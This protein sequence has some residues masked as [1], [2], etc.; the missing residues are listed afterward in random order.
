MEIWKN[1]I[2]YDEIIRNPKSIPPLWYSN[3][4]SAE[5]VTRDQE[6]LLKSKNRKKN[7]KVDDFN[8]V[9]SSLQEWKRKNIDN[10]PT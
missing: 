8:N 1:Q 5:K 10:K 4:F 7:M 2:P 9:P 6:N 3:P